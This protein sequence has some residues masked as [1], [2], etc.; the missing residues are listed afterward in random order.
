VRERECVKVPTATE[1]LGVSPS[2]ITKAAKIAVAEGW[3]MSSPGPKGGYRVGDAASAHLEPPVAEIP[4]DT[5]SS[6]LI[7]A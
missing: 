6:E 5:R 4:S 7:G 1:V 3:I 2:V